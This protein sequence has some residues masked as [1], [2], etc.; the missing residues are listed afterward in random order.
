MFRISII[1]VALSSNNIICGNRKVYYYRRNNISSACTSFNINNIY[2]GEYSLEVVKTML[3]PNSKIIDTMFELHSKMY[4]LGALVK[5]KS[6]GLEEKYS[7]DCK[8]W[9]K[10]IKSNILK[11]IFKPNIPIYRKL[12]LFC[13]CVFPNLITSLYVWRQKGIIKNSI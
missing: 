2:N 1:H 10:T 6:N 7:Y 3:P 8:R 13:S 12:L 9:F 4:S 11:F 5:V